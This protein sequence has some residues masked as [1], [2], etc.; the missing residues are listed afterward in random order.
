MGFLTRAL[1]PHRVRRAMHPLRTLK[2]GATP[3]VAKRGYG[4]AHPA[5]HVANKAAYKVNRGLYGPHK[6]R[7]H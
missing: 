1:M 4:L 6:R 2:W 7:R 5:H 3:R